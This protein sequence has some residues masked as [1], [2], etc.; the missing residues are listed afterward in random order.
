MPAQVR[1]RTLCRRLA[2]CTHSYSSSE[3]LRCVQRRGNDALV[4]GAAA[5]V[6][7]N[8]DPHLL[9]GGIGIVAQEFG[10]RSQHAGR[11]ETALQAVV[12]AERFLQGTELGVTGGKAFN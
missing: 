8:G 5:E 10:E 4:A 9:L 1:S 2:S 3:S 11:A 12:V 7:G 6:A